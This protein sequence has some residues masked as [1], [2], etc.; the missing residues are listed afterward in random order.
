MINFKALLLTAVLAPALVACGGK[1]APVG[2]QV[3]TTTVEYTATVKGTT[4]VEVKCKAG[5]VNLIDFP[6]YSNYWM[7][8]QA[9]YDIARQQATNDGMSSMAS[10]HGAF[11]Q[12][13]ANTA[14]SQACN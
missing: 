13:I 11:I 3:K 5:T 9:S 4:E 1:E 12:G 2:D 14:I 7:T 10:H 8:S 6:A